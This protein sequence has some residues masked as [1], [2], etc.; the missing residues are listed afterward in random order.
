MNRPSDPIFTTRPAL[1]LE[2][3]LKAH[4]RILHPEQVILKIGHYY[5]DLGALCYALRSNTMRKSGQPREVVI[6]SLIKQRPKQILQLIKA[7]SGLYADGGKGLRTV[8]NYSGNLKKFLDWADTNSLHDCLAG[9][10]ATRNAFR[11]WAADTQE[12]YKR[13]EFGEMAHNQRLALVSELLQATTGLDDIMRGIRKV[14]HVSN[15]NGGTAP[16]ALHD[17]AHGV[18]LNQ[19]LFDGLCDL[20]LDQNPF[21]YKLDLPASLGWT[22]NH[23]WLF[24]THVWR[25]PPR[26]WSAER[27]KLGASSSWAYDY[28]NGRLA[29]P[30]E[31]AHRYGFSNFPSERRQRARVAIKGAQ[32]R[33]D[34]ANA[35]PQDS[36]RI[37]LGMLAQRAF[38]FLF[39]CNT[40][41]NVQVVLDLETDGNP[42]EATTLKQGW[43]EIKYRAKGKIVALRAPVNFLPRL[44][45][46]MELRSYLLKNKGKTFPYLFFT[47]GVEN[48]KAAA[49]LHNAP[50]QS[51]YIHVLQ[52]IDPNL[53]PMQ[54]RV[55]RAS[56]DDYYQRLH[57]PVV[58]AAV[59]GHTVETEEKKYNAGSEHEHHEELSLLLTKVAESARKQRVIPVKSINPDTPPLEGG[60]RCESYQHPEPLA[61]NP[62]VKPDC[63]DSQGCLFCKHRVLVADEEDVRKVASAAYVMEQLLIGPQHEEALRPLISKCDEDLEKIAAFRNS[64]AMVNTVR[65]DVYQNEH[66]TPFW[67]DKYQLFLEL[68][69]IA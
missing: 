29:T 50:L 67:A 31:I 44:R 13:Q 33:M 4:T 11:A 7:L 49:K 35:D 58:A 10:D 42:P 6:S 19:A 26:L 59:M 39:F 1:T 43:R 52:M 17:F 54:S 68:G 62:P 12:R 40:G 16:L 27:E 66:L 55:L 63:K 64:R 38:L 34:A 37:M 14:K 9:G 2:L 5:H 22:E 53:P 3:P 25:L 28:E 20:V 24:P 57:G 30:D 65:K 69:V 32:T 48:A 41:G 61:D 46:F 23:L 51:L 45:R 8:D 47:Y 36:Y 60:G 15:P 21:P 56:V 18:A